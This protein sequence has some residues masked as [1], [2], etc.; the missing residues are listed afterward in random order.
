MPRTNRPAAPQPARLTPEEMRAAIP[1]LQRRIADLEAF[2]PTTVQDRHDP[3]IRELEASIDDTLVDVFGGDTLDYQRYRGAK[4]LDRAA[5][6]I[7]RRTPIQEV[8]EGLQRGKAD[9][10]ALLSTARRALQEKFEDLLPVEAADVASEE[11][12]S[13]AA[14]PNVFVVHGHDDAAREQVARFIERAGLNPIILHEQA[15][16]GRTVIEKLEHYADVGFAVV[17]LTPDDQGGPA[18]GPLQPRAGQNVMAKL[19]YFLGRLGRSRVCALK[20]GDLEI[21]SDIGGVVYVPFDDHGGWKQA[22]LRELEIAGYPVDWS[23]LR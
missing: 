14:N 9:A 18:D 10:I 21:P 19:F 22:L 6:Y 15:S 5:S 16:G 2:D 23:S 12:A 13:I 1:R 3:R 4:L 8:V 7:N 20:K 11:P 17:L